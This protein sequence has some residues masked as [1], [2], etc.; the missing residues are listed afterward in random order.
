MALGNPPSPPPNC[1]GRILQTSMPRVSWRG[2]SA[3][4][5]IREPAVTLTAQE[6][7]LRV[8]AGAN[9]LSFLDSAATILSIA[10]IVG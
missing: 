8:L 5:D 2:S 9:D 1:R 6:R 3:A 7:V 4:A 10:S